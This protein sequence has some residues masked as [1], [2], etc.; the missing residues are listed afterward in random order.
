MPT[1]PK[2][3]NTGLYGKFQVRRV[4][5][6]DAPGQKHADCEY[7]VLDLTHDRHAIPAIRA[8]AESCRHR[9][10]ALASDLERIANTKEA[11]RVLAISEGWP[12]DD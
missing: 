8:Y 6:R 11:G 9:F 4:D 3:E 12:T 5:G 2:D 1:D 10:P 7:F